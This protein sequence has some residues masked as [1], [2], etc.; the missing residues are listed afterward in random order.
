[1]LKAVSC[2][3]I[4]ITS[5]T[6]RYPITVNYPIFDGVGLCYAVVPGRI[7]W[8]ESVVLGSKF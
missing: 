3:Q 6:I 4:Y 5:Y 8:D 7:A 1:V 2:Y